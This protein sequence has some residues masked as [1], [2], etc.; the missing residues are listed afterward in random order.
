MASNTKVTEYR[1]KIRQDKAGRKAKNQRAIH[2]TTPAFPI[3]TP[4]ADAN[5]PAQV[6]P[7]VKAD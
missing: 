6:S 3:H 5:A 7:T 2:G 1:R 4:E